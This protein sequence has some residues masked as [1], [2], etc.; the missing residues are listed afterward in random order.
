MRRVN[1]REAVIAVLSGIAVVY[2][3][4]LLDSVGEAM[5]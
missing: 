4:R 2:I 5:S 3:V 1:K